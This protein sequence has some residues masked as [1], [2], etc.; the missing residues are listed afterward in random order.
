MGRYKGWEISL[1]LGFF[2]MWFTLLRILWLESGITDN[3][4]ISKY[5]VPLFAGYGLS[6][7]MPDASEADLTSS[8]QKKGW[9]PHFENLVAF[10][11]R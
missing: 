10:G 9:I 1:C 7:A 8:A 2:S 3:M 4:K 5:S 11:D 6:I